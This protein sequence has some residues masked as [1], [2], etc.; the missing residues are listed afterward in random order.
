MAT[1]NRDAPLVKRQ[2]LGV[3]KDF[4]QATTR[5]KSRIFTP[6]RVSGASAML[7]LMI[8]DIKSN[9]I[10]DYRTRLV[11]FR[12]LHLETAGQDN[13]PNYNVDRQVLADI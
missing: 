3:E 1:V 9:R 12:P 10:I 4:G 8:E 5:Q 2:K 13:F 7:F 11:H 6:F